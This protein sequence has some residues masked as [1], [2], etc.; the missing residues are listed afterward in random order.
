MKKWLTGFALVAVI[1]GILVV[2]LVVFG[3]ETTIREIWNSANAWI[4]GLFNAGSGI[5][6]AS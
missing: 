3:N 5:Q 6:I 4:G 2:V 1:V